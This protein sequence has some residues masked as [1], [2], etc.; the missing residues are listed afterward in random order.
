MALN[1]VDPDAVF[2]NLSLGVGFARLADGRNLLCEG[3]LNLK[4][5]PFVPI[6][7]LAGG[8]SA[9]TLL[10]TGFGGL[11]LARGFA[12]AFRVARF[13]SFAQDFTRVDGF[14]GLRQRHE[15]YGSNL[16]RFGYLY[17]QAE[18]YVS[19]AVFYS[20]ERRAAYA[21][22]VAEANLADSRAFAQALHVEADDVA[23][24]GSEDFRR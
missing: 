10:C 12:R 11:V 16:E 24:F 22:H 15:V 4:I 21:Q 17:Q 1:Y 14:V 19:L 6:A 9:F 2:G 5:R 7:C 8:R 23:L 18:A 3:V 13:L 20:V